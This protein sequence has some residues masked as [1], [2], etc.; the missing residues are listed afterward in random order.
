VPPTLPI[1]DTDNVVSGLTT[2]GKRLPSAR[3]LDG[4]LAGRVRLVVP[5][6]LLA[7]DRA[8]LLRPRVRG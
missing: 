3:I 7:E 5:I 6:A 4:M 1:V 2:A 8:V